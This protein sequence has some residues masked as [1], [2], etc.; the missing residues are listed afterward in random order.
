MDIGLFLTNQHPRGTDMHHALDEQ[1]ELMRLA[2]DGG[3]DSVFT[4]QHLLTPDSTQLQPGP[5][6]ARLA[7]ES[8]HLTLGLGIL[9]LTSANP[10]TVAEELAS[11][12]VVT[13]GRL[14]AG[15]GLGYR[16]EE[17][18]AYG[19]ARGQRARR[20]EA[21]L[22]VVRRLWTGEPT[23]VDLPWCSLDE[24][25][26]AAV[27]IQAGGPRVWIGATSDAAVRRATRLGDGWMIN[28]SVAADDVLAQ[29]PIIQ[30]RRS[31]SPFAV[32]AFK[33]I[34]CAPTREEAVRV[35]GAEMERKYRAYSGW[36]Q[37]E[38]HSSDPDLRDLS[39]NL[40]ARRFIAGDPEDCYRELK[41]WHEEVGIDNFLLRCHWI[42]TPL[43]VTR[44]S[45]DLLTKE[46]LPALRAEAAR[47]R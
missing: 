35:G 14:V 15:V 40:Q 4:G 26:I 18:D 9:L 23:S 10:V 22:D 41:W 32:T 39:D 38:A 2:R 31:R 43:E 21:N 16:T 46:V 5:F 34:Y 25:T 12:D 1:L 33:E 47:P 6:L 20:F 36:G 3:W 45:V 28:P 27:P 17:F 7:A 42:G 13:G 8:D 30:E 37:A 11:L 24:A 19:V 44:R 29:R